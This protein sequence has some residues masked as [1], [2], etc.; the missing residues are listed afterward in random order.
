MFVHW[1]KQAET[2][3][4]TICGHKEIQGGKVGRTI[5]S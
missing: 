3:F 2:D 4:I 5:L 1:S